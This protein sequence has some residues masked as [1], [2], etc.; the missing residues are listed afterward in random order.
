ML[1]DSER[2]LLPLLDAAELDEEEDEEL[3]SYFQGGRKGSVGGGAKPPPTFQK[4]AFY[5][6]P[7]ILMIV[8]TVEDEDGDGE[9]SDSVGEMVSVADVMRGS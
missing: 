4:V 9:A 7:G 5:E 1:I 2:R 6:D 8:Q 3:E